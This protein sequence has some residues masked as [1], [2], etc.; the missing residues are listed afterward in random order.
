MNNIISIVKAY[1]RDHLHIGGPS[2]SS[3]TGVIE[4]SD[5]EPSVTASTS[6]TPTSTTHKPVLKLKPSSSGKGGIKLKLLSTSAPSTKDTV[7]VKKKPASVVGP[8][9]VR[10]LEEELALLREDS[11]SQED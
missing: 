11:D 2:V 1:R 6:R 8:V 4:L 7:K 5:T 9:E 10:T 3:T